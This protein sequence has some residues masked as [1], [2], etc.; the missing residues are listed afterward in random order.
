M[1]PEYDVGYFFAFN[2]ECQETPACQITPEFRQRQ[3]PSR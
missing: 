3:R 1:I 2:A